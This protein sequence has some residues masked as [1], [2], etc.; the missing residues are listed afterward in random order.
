M[1]QSRAKRDPLWKTH[2]N[3][4]Q[5]LSTN[6]WQS[7]LLLY[8]SRMFAGLYF[9][10]QI[11]KHFFVRYKS[12]ICEIILFWHHHFTI[13]DCRNFN[14]FGGLVIFLAILEIRNDRYLPLGSK[15]CDS[16]ANFYCLWTFVKLLL[17]CD[18]AQI[19]LLS[20]YN[21]KRNRTP[22]PKLTV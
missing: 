2:S 10:E 14:V 3:L 18:H 20:E 5:S 16:F 9:G 22:D 6:F 1:N 4:W 11:Y 21:W 17:C 13:R 19:R 12:E 8:L 7:L 15:C